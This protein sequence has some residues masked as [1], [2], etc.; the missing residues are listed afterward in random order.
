[1]HRYHKNQKNDQIYQQN[2]HAILFN[3]VYTDQTGKFVRNSVREH[4]K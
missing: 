1:M 2:L 3:V 4:T